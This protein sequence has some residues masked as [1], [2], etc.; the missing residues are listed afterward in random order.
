MGDKYNQGGNNR[1]NI[2]REKFFK[3]PDLKDPKYDYD[4]DE[5][6]INRFKQTHFE[7]E[8]GEFVNLK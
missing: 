3:F 7:Y 2:E 4:G 5:S 6:R 8:V 1:V